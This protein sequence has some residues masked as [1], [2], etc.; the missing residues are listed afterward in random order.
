V[1]QAGAKDELFGPIAPIIKVNGEGALS[2]DF[3]ARC[4]QEI[5]NGVCSLR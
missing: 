1:G 4:P 5:A 2:T 3:Q